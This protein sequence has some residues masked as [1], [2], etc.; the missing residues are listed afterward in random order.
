MGQHVSATPGF[1]ASCF[2]CMLSNHLSSVLLCAGQPSSV[3]LLS[4]SLQ[5]GKGAEHTERL[6]SEVPACS[7]MRAHLRI[8]AH[9]HQLILRSA[10]SIAAFL[11]R[12]GCNEIRL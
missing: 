12:R 6:Y 10:P 5:V 4:C 3:L 9:L 11:G 7:R 1:S 2:F 8:A